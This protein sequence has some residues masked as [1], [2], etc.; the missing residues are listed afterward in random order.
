M[1]HQFNE[2]KILGLPKWLQAPRTDVISE[3]LGEGREEAKAQESAF[4]KPP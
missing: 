4:F 1:S 3:S 2:D